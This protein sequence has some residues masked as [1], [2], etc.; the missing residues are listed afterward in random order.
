MMAE[1]RVD[2]IYFT[3]LKFLNIFPRHD[4][5]TKLKCVKLLFTAACMVNT[6][7]PVHVSDLRL[8]DSAKIYRIFSTFDKLLLFI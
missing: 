4:R 5:L 6:V 2:Q 8:P 7:Y 3:I 1:R